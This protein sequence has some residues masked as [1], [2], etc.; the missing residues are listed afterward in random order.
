MQRDRGIGAAVP[1]VEDRRFLTGEGRFG[2]DLSA[3]GQAYAVFLRSPHA[4]A[5]L[6]RI[7]V[8]AARAAAG[9]RLVLTAEDIQGE[10]RK[11]IPS[12]SATPPFDIARRADGSAAEADQYPLAQ[13]RVRF[14]GEA[15]ACVVA[16]SVSAARDAA[17]LIEVEYAALPAA[18]GIA[19]A[20][21][22]GAA[23]VWEQW[24]D[25]L[26]FEWQRGDA[27]ATEAAFAAAAQIARV[28]LVN[29]RVAI[30]FLEPR[31][32]LA[33][34][35]A[36]QERFTLTTGCQSAHGQQALL[37]D[38]LGIDRAKLRV[39][40]PNMGGGFGARGSVYPETPVLLAA[41]RRLGRP[42][43]WT[44]ERTESFLTDTQSRDHLMRGELAL[45]GAGNFTALRVAIDWR[46]GAYLTSR[47]I[48]V[49]VAY[50]PPT[51]GGA[52][53]I[54]VGHVSMRGIFTNTA[55]LGAY[56]GIGRVESNYLMESLVD[57]AARVSGQDR[58]ELRR[59]NLVRADELPWRSPGG[60]T[61]ELGEFHRNLERGLALSDW[62]GAE[63]RRR[64]ARARGLLKG[65]G[66]ALY[67]ENDGGTPTEYAEIEAEADGTVTAYVGTQDFGMGHAT[68]YAQVLSSRLGIDFE[69]VRVVFGDTDR[70][71]RGAGSH[72]SRSARLGGGAVVGGALKLV[73][74]GTELASEML[75]AAASD[76]EYRQG[77]FV[78]AGTDRAVSLQA[79]AGFAASR[80]ERLA[81][82]ADFVT[83]R[84]TH[85]NGCHVAEVTVDPGD[86]RVRVDRYT[87]VAD[88]GRAVNPLIVDG[89]LHGGAA[90][91]LGQALMEAVA[92]EPSSGQMLSGSYMDYA[93][94]RADELPFFATELNEQAETDNP[95]GAKGAGESATTG[96]PG[97]LMNAIRDALGPAAGHLDMPATPARI[98]QAL[99]RSRLPS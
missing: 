41:A 95:L 27:A 24:P 46:H 14:V 64:Q 54:P 8:S 18:I 77:D 62:N 92:Y 25:N 21:A 49:M 45:D 72:G 58:I 52:Y 94:P 32:A 13:R 33:A 66:L 42:V 9:V 74:R 53:R 36:G 6:R 70:V 75:E 60:A 23:G 85:S 57:E 20:A 26:S 79:V 98:W 99:K 29:N 15:V 93:L 78:V 22:P 48:W 3:P 28:E 1:R 38:M 81:G 65:I 88:V 83:K 50:L 84:E 30:S 2:D 68:M 76:I 96:A 34:Y 5:E 43:K 59:R 91:G 17:E 89:Q 7:E 55:P 80:G 73:E 12:F 35:D 16:D 82:A 39:V 87:V 47:S 56:R 67:V 69:R 97:A 61:Y 11:P 10:V 31:A 63:A 51:L 86:G 44:A 19:E 4:H 71:A 40:V 90:Q 37:A